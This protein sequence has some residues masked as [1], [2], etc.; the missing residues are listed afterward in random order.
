[1]RRRV[2][3][4]EW[5]EKHRS[6]KI[7]EIYVFYS[8][9]NEISRPQ[10]DHKFDPLEGSMSTSSYMMLAKDQIA[11]RGESCWCNGCL[12]ARGRVNMTSSDSKLICDNCTHRNKPVWMQQTIRDLGTGRLF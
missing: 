8:P 11:R 1:M 7:H 10:A 6:K 4:A 2:G 5:T 9:H 3:S 12:C